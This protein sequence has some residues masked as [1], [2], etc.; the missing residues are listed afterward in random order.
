LHVFTV[1][2][3]E[4]NSRKVRYYDYWIDPTLFICLEAMAEAE[5]LQ[6]L[7]PAQASPRVSGF[8]CNQTSN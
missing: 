4:Q 7:A 6:V 3:Q 8:R 2:L 1:Q 5:T